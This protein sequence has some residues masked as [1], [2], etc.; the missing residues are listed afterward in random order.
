MSQLGKNRYG[1]SYYGLSGVHAG[2]FVTDK[3][4]FATPLTSGLEGTTG[5]LNIITTAKLAKASYHY[6]ESVYGSLPNSN[7]F[8]RTGTWLPVSNSTNITS[9]DPNFSLQVNVVG[10]KIKI[11]YTQREI[12]GAIINVKVDRFDPS[13]NEIIE[14]VYN[15]LVNTKTSNGTLDISSSTLT[16]GEYI[17]TIG[18]DISS[19]PD[20]IFEFNNISLEVCDIAIEY[21]MLNEANVWSGW[22]LGAWDS[23]VDLG[24]DI[25]RYSLTT[26]N[27]SGYKGYQIKLMMA[28]GDNEV[29]PEIINLAI[30]SG[31]T[32]DFAQEGW[33]KTTID[34]KDPDGVGNN[35]TID[36][37][38]IDGDMPEGTDLNVY[39]RTS[40]SDGNW[41]YWSYPYRLDTPDYV[42]TI[43][44]KNNNGETYG[45]VLSPLYY[46]DSTNSFP[47]SFYNNSWLSY[48]LDAELGNYDPITKAYSNGQKI[49]IE[50]VNRAYDPEHTTMSTNGN[51]SSN[52]L[53]AVE[54]TKK[55]DIFKLYEILN[56]VKEPIR[57]KTNFIR[58]SRYVASPCL[59][60][61]H[62][63]YKVVYDENK[64][65]RKNSHYSGKGSSIFGTEGEMSVFIDDY[66]TK[67]IVGIDSSNN[68]LNFNLVPLVY[69]R[70]NT[71]YRILPS[72]T[73]FRSIYK[74]DEVQIY[75]V[76]NTKSDE[77]TI[78]TESYTITSKVNQVTRTD[79]RIKNHY[80]YGTGVVLHIEPSYASLRVDNLF[81]PYLDEDK[82]YIYA[83][84]NGYSND[85]V[86]NK[87]HIAW[88]NP[89]KDNDDL[90]N[91]ASSLS[92]DIK[93]QILEASSSKN[94]LVDWSSN[95][96]IHSA[97]VNAN[98][99]EKTISVTLKKEDGTLPGFEPGIVFSG[100]NSLGGTST[101][102]IVPYVIEIVE[103][104]VVM[105][106]HYT[107]N[108]IYLNGQ[109]QDRILASKSYI[110]R[111]PP[112]NNENSVKEKE[113]VR[114]PIIKSSSLT[115]YLP[116][117]M[118]KAI[119]NV[120]LPDGTPC[121]LNLDYDYDVS[122]NTYSNALIWLEGGTIP[123]EGTT[124][125]VSY[126]YDDIESIKL[127]FS[128]PYKEFT[129]TPNIYR[130]PIQV[131]SGRCSPLYDYISSALDISKFNIPSSVDRTTCKFVVYD[132][133]PYVRT[134]LNGNKVVGTMDR[135]D[136]KESWKPTINNGFYY[137]DKNKYYM[138]K[139]KS[140]AKIGADTIPMA[141][142][143]KYINGKNGSGALIEDST[144]N[145]LVNTE[146]IT[147]DSI[148][149]I[150]KFN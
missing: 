33:W 92:Q 109:K 24:S 133:N 32:N 142:N 71:I 9:S 83:I 80:K 85:T 37:L 144:N 108:T 90:R 84:R 116:H 62:I 47:L 41:E 49:M 5:T 67:A 58:A 95:E 148:E 101:R 130:S 119:S 124:F 26:P 93:V 113:V 75:F 125:F 106:G 61:V 19:A 28:T 79:G 136:P 18:Y 63:N 44:S 10:K 104:S 56:N 25:Y 139:N 134:Y 78:G 86:N 77:V 87:V 57:I 64:K 111:Q 59:H 127:E 82:T 96:K 135:I 65:F 140:T 129:Y 81:S 120:Y 15:E 105:N 42:Y 14:D 7:I 23:P 145:I 55:S 17:V 94:G 131:F 27:Y 50:I 72:D 29:G 51:L 110:F 2:Q 12:D 22:I 76:G 102:G 112:Y 121:M 53:M 88:T 73:N 137:I 98:D 122:N 6:Y 138:Y 1:A 141:T 31:N 103:G 13:T 66:D 30:E 34:L 123:S 48:I 70:E 21:K 60:N 149:P 36:N 97:T 8:I 107:P 45:Y 146:F 147:T 143:L 126:T 16:Y 52:V 132:N 43:N 11:G 4:L 20:S 89:M 46:P 91:I 115:D 150:Y 68:T 40:D 35:Y 114:M 38:V 54:Y 99:L 74:N 39:V 128:C 118:I 3:T 117:P 69:G 100:D